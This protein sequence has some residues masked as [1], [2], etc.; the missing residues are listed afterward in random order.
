MNLSGEK[1]FECD[2]VVEEKGMER[3]RIY[4]SLCRYTYK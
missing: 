3:V 1:K 2:K 4:T